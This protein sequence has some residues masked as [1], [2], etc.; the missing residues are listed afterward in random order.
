[1]S[2]NTSITEH[3]LGDGSSLLV[4]PFEDG[5]MLASVEKQ[6]R[7]ATDT[8]TPSGT[9]GGDGGPASRITDSSTA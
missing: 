1:M 7:R 8:P 6:L 4:S 3:Q 5:D 2:T 9:G